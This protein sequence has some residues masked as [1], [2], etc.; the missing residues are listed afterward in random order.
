MDMHK[1]RELRA[2]KKQES[3]NEEPGKMNINWY[4]GHM[5]KTRRQ[6]K[7]KLD[8]IDIIYEV[9]DA[10]IP[11]SSKIID[12][13]DLIKNKPKILIMTKYDLCD[14]EK[15]SKWIKYY[16]N[17]GYSVIITDLINSNDTKK[18]LDL[19]DKVLEELKTKRMNK[20]LLE[21]RFRVLVIGVPNVGKSTLINK[22]VGKKVATVGNKPG[23][24]KHLAWIR[25]NDKLELLDSPGILWPKIDNEISA[26]NLASLTAIKQ[27]ILPLDDVALYILNKLNDNYPH[28][29]KE[30]Y[31][32]NNYNNDDIL[33]ILDK[34]GK[35]RGCLV[36]GGQIDHDKVM[37]I[38]VNDVKDGK[39]KGITF[40]DIEKFN[41]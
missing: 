33:E 3:N 14:K 13:L 31:D 11:Y 22:L 41:I 16:E 18:I 30:Q 8:L 9:V 7:E 2:K 26:Y 17:L 15:T 5:A 19:S 23:V 28:I 20:G 6:I 4:P 27:E 32:I 10:R 36:K 24:T 35:K 12:I 38:I 37:I 40:D 21:K 1:K 39:I 34:I 25:I 29:L